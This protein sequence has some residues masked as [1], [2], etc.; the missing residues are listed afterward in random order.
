MTSDSQMNMILHIANKEL[1]QNIKTPRFLI[2]FV[3]CILLIPFT[4]VISIH[5]YK[6]KISQ[7][8][9]EKKLA[10]EEN[11]V[12]VYSAFRPVIIKQ[13]SPLSI[14][15]RGIS[16][17]MGNR[18]KVLFGDKP[19]MT[20]GKAES[21]DNPFLNRFFTFDFITILII[22][23]SLLAFLFTYDLCTSERESGTLKMML[24][25]SVSRSA[26]LMGKLLGTFLTVLPF[27]IFSFGLCLLFILLERDIYFS[28]SEW[29]RI[30]VI[31]LL[32]L[33]FLILFLIIGL[34]VSSRVMQS[35]TSMVICLLIWVVCLFLIPNMANYSARSIVEVGSI[36]NLDL[37]IQAIEAEFQNKL[38]GY[39]VNLPEPDWNMTSTYWTS[40]DGFK[41][42]GG[43]TKSFMDIERIKTAYSEQLRIQ[44]ADK[45]WKYRQAYLD[46]IHLQQRLSRLI[47]F[48]SP[49]EIFK[50]SVSGMCATDYI[51]HLNF[52]KQ[53]A[54]YRETLITYYKENN[55]FD[56][57]TY[58]NAINPD[59]YLTADEMI[60]TRTNGLCES[61]EEFKSKFGGDY[62][63]LVNELAGSNLWE[64]PLLDVST[65]PSFKFKPSGILSDVRDSLFYFGLLLT[66]AVVLFFFSY[67]SFSRYDVR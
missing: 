31:F 67:L 18:I 26:I 65:L 47:S 62:K 54:V 13:P 56:S 5:E 58:F 17:N 16:Y 46:K 33:A 53:V 11:K 61:L 4:M 28:T 42:I 50:E 37:D 30:I 7:Y 32:S 44:Y 39:E 19:M 60:K 52:L 10:D 21:R 66:M 59:H 34:F 57:Y 29:I 6:S 49:A 20:V 23:I 25:N 45:K 40:G 63:Y 35:G 24:S 14:F 41:M 27:L 3:L 1:Y 15:G 55:L 51:S 36:E 43:A 48:L 22:I 64:W 12:R 8:E 2:G 38:A 9:I